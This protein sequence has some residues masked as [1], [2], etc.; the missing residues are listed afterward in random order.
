TFR[1]QVLFWFAS[2][3]LL[4]LFLYVFSSILLPFLAG[5]ALAYFL[6]P[7]ADRLERLGLTRTAATVVILIGFVIVLVLA[8][9]LVI[10]VLVNQVRDFMLRLPDYLAMLQSLI[11]ELDP[12]WFEEV[13]GVDSAALR[14]GLNSLLAQGTGFIATLFQSIWTSGLALV[15]LISLFVVTPVVAFYML[16]DWDR[17]IARIDDWVPRNQVETVRSLGREINTVVAGFVRGQG[18]VC[19]IL[20]AI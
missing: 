19:L 18:T 20:G 11:T 14:E 9:L 4:I 13:L 17:M 2:A 16:L 5:M 8:L 3:F 6:D 12:A 15:N 1:R 10:P 7:V